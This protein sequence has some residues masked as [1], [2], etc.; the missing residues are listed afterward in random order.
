MVTTVQPSYE[1]IEQHLDVEMLFPEA[2]HF[3]RRRRLKFASMAVIVASLSA[4]VWLYT[5]STS[6]P[7]APVRVQTSGAPTQLT[8]KNVAEKVCKSAL[9]GPGTGIRVIHAYPSTDGLLRTW[10][11]TDSEVLGPFPL[12]Q[13]PRSSHMTVCYVAGAFAPDVPP[14]DHVKYDR[15]LYVVPTASDTTSGRVGPVFAL[16]IGSAPLHFTPP[17]T[18]S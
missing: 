8:P 15:A 14:G 12:N 9:A 10:W 7:S 17:P 2:R 13:Y 18:R 1:D 3:E 16:S 6:G 4:G 5:R 11:I